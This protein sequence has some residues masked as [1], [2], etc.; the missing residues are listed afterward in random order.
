MRKNGV[1]IFYFDKE[2]AK[3]YPAYSNKIRKIPLGFL[4]NIADIGIKVKPQIET[5]QFKKWFRDSKVVGYFGP[6]PDRAFQLRCRL[7]KACVSDLSDL[8]DTRSG[9]RGGVLFF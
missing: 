9:N 7:L 1:G 3:R 5:F 4:H 6:F 2:K 8:S